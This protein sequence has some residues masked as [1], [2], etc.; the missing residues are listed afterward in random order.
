ME[1]KR[2]CSSFFPV[3]TLGILCL[4][5]IGRMTCGVRAHG[6]MCRV[7]LTSVF[8]RRRRFFLYVLSLKS[9]STDLAVILAARAGAAATEQTVPPA[10]IDDAGHREHVAIHLTAMS[11][12]AWR[13]LTLTRLSDLLKCNHVRSAVHGAATHVR[14]RQLPT[15]PNQ[16]K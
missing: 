7:R 1:C 4:P 9:R 10:L 11:H 5:G 15:R 8:L 16:P 6:S 12:H 3:D 14:I 2:P 13:T